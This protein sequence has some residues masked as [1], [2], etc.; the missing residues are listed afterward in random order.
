MTIKCENISFQYGT[1]EVLNNISMQFEKGYLYGIIGPNGCGKSTFLKILSG[2]LKTNYGKVLIDEDNINKLMIREIAKKIA[3]VPQST[4]INFDFSVREIIK[5]GRY[6]HVGRFSRESIKDINVVDQILNKFN[7]TEIQH[8]GFNELS[9]GEQQK[10]IISRAIAQ[11]SEV[12]LLDEPTSQLDLNY[13]IE[14]MEMLKNYVKDGLIVII[15][16][17]DLNLATLFCDKIILLNAGHIEAFG[18]IEET[19]TKEN[20]LSVYNIEIAIRKN[21]FTNSIYITPLKDRSHISRKCKLKEGKRIHVIAG[22]GSALEIL[23]KLKNNIVSIGIL[24]VLDDDFSL[25]NELNY[26]IISEA[27]F[28]PISEESKNKLRKVL[29]NVDLIIL[30]NMPFG[31]NNIENLHILNEC[32]KKIIIYELEP[33]ENRDFTGGLATNVY[34][35]LINKSNVMVVNNLETLFQK[36]SE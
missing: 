10:V 26:R 2:I 34:L 33:I 27:P 3:I 17:H 24:N 6:S 29:E 5:M 1:K 18:S 35:N 14:L 16:L 31:Y 30:G 19:I 36:I 22:G 23:P 32:E 13:K 11:E 8:R 12:L 7:L 21:L 9:G 4:S 28:S 25:A 15:V 20:I